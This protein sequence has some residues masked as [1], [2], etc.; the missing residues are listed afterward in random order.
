MLREH[1]RNEGCG[2]A[3]ER[4]RQPEPEHQNAGMMPG[5]TRHREHVVEGHGDVRD[6]DLGGGLRQGLLP[7]P[8]AAGGGDAAVGI[9]LEVLHG[10]LARFLRG[11]RTQLAPHLPAY[12]QQ[13]NA[14]GE[15]QADHL[16]EL[17]RHRREGDAQQRRRDDADEDRARAL[18][19]RQTGGRE[20]DNDRIVPGQNQVD[21]DH[22][23]QR[24]QGRAAEE[25]SHQPVDHRQSSQ[26]WAFVRSAVARR[27]LAPGQPD[28]RSGGIGRVRAQGARTGLDTGPLRCCPVRHRSARLP[29]GPGLVVRLGSSVHGDRRR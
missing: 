16:Q 8:A 20:A 23:Q 28:R 29:E 12:P 19:C 17:G 13:Q 18:R 25:F 9:D 15:Q 24:S 22:L 7:G 10:E 21:H 6:D 14:A 3:H 5:R 4:D 2:Q 27:L 1:A 26:P 11:N